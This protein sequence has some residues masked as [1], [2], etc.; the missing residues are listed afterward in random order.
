MQAQD[1]ETGK[2]QGQE[3]EEKEGKEP[4]AEQR[5]REKYDKEE[6]KQERDRA[7]F[8]EKLSDEMLGS[9]FCTLSLLDSIMTQIPLKESKIL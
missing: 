8:P 4:K 2:S 1:E 3:A 5:Q 7:A 6:G 9:V